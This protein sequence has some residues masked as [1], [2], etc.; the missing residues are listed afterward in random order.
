MSD[1]PCHSRQT[2]A[3]KRPERK[4]LAHVPPFSVNASYAIWF[5]TICAAQRDGGPLLPYAAAILES[6]R[7]RHEHGLWF[8]TLLL[9]MPDHVH[10]L[11]AVP[12]G[13][14]LS[15]AI[16]D[17]KHYLSCQCGIKFQPNFFD[18]RI[19]D[20]AHYAEKWAY[21]VRNPVSRGLVKTPRE[22]P[23]VIAFDRV[24]GKELPHR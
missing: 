22:W 15:R 13:Q 12:P 18:V 1:L 16:G 3:E 4:T 17:W 21:V 5:V 19:R 23:H 10:M 24:T 14:D 7:Y 2:T 8:L 9:V 20:D 11:V 6:A